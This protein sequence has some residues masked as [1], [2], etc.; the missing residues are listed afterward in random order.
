MTAQ[1]ELIIDYDLN[2]RVTAITKS[3]CHGREIMSEKI[4]RIGLVGFGTV[5][6]GVAKIIL[7]QADII[8]AKTGLQLELA[9]V[10]DTETKSPREVK[11]PPHILTNDLNKLLS[12][13]TI[14]IAV[15]FTFLF[16]L[17]KILHEEQETAILFPIERIERG[18]CG[19]VPIPADPAER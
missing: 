4:I 12:D 9:C 1:K 17:Q 13:N 8:A 5:G 7:S 19:S 15:P 6:S 18:V 2:N 14:K 10:V 3:P 16:P 11:L